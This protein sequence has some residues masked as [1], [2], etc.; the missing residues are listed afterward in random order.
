LA[1]DVLAFGDFLAVVFFVV[2]FL[3]VVFFGLLV[4]VFFAAGFLV[5]IR[6]APQVWAPCI[7]KIDFPVGA[8]AREV[9]SAYVGNRRRSLAAFGRPEIRDLRSRQKR[10]ER[11]LRAF[12]QDCAFSV[13]TSLELVGFVA[14]VNAVLNHRGH[15]VH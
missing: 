11:L 6:L 4:A 14:V 10:L 2:V 5:A 1:F 8:L 9:A 12:K 3:A 7:P 15:G 13:N